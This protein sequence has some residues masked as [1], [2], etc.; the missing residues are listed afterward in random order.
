LCRYD[1]SSCPLGVS[2]AARPNVVDWG[3]KRG[4]D[5]FLGKMEWKALVLV[6]RSAA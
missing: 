5:S 4:R 2:F 6:K 1:G 3:Q